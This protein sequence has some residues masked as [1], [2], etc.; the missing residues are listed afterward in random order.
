M[1]VMFGARRLTCRRRRLFGL[2]QRD[3]GTSLR[4]VAGEVII[5]KTIPLQYLSNGDAAKLV[6]PYVS[7]RVG[8]TGD[9]ASSG[10]FEAGNAVHA[11]TVRASIVMIAR[12][13]SIVKAN[14]RPPATLT[15]RLQVDCR[16]RFLRAR[17]SDQRDR[18]R[19]P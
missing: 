8:A 6:A 16:E 1:L 13:D 19:T 5:V 18:R 4:R 3:R 10:V 2:A 9:A 14:D 7:P 17:R 11:I 15:L 12:I